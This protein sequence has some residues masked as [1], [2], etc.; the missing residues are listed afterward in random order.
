[1]RIAK[2]MALAGVDSRRKCEQYILR[3]EVSLNGEVI[4][5]LGRQVNPDEDQIFFRNRVL[6][7]KKYIYLMLYKPKGYT[8]TTSD[9]HA[10]K[11][12]FELLPR[13]LVVRR[14]QYRTQNTRVFPV[15]RLDRDTAGLLLFTNDG[16]LANQLIH[17][18][19]GVE[20]WYQVRL[21]RAFESKDI[22]ALK[23][24]I[25]LEEGVAKAT[26]VKRASVRVV[27]IAL[28]EGKK[29]EVR[30]MFGV[31][32]YEVVDLLRY[33]FGPLTLGNLNLGECR[34][35]STEEIAA[36]KRTAPETSP[37][38]SKKSK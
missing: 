26:K 24:G 32:N 2:A 31:L 27:C 12:V 38:P 37:R 9:S 18:R 10:K 14:Q 17:P 30:R 15:G 16:D 35:L 11:T 28:R 20:K 8:T 36:L 23:E 5:D 25:P 6:S 1:M 3:G 13:N 22:L 19:Y 21:D 29:R 7:F 33:A 4:Y 34:Y